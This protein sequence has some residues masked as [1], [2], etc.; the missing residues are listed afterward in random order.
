MAPL[1]TD[2]VSQ[3]EEQGYVVVEEVFDPERDLDPVLA[4]Y[5]RVLDRLALRLHAEGTLP[6]AYTELDFSARLSR[7]CAETGELYSQHFDLSLPQRGVT[8]NT[9][10]WTGPAVFNLLRHDQLLD[11]VESLI[12]PEIFSNPVQHVRLIPPE[13]V[14]PKDPDTGNVRLGPTPWHQDNGVVTEDADDTP[15]VTV[16]FPLLDVTV[17]TGCLVVVPGSHKTGLLTHCGGGGLHVPKALFDPS[18]GTPL[19]IPRGTVL[20]MHR[21]TLHSSLPNRSDQVRSSLDLRYQPVGQPT[22][23]SAF[24]GFVARSR[25]RPWT[26]LRDPAQWT[27]LWQEARR[28]LADGQP[29][30]FN[31][32]DTNS[33]V[34]A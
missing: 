2:Q 33:P 12:G 16:W 27:A 10:F 11:R 28:A 26:E 15:T 19:P 22:G 21:Q 32:W 7:I 20:F 3:F 14:V 18:Q 23:R 13:Q 31:R 4:E 24:P 5:D 8:H 30:R 17:E 6:S 25:S 29:P 34:C 1:T 9:P